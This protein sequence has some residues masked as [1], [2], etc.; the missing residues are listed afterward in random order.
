M[1]TKFTGLT[2]AVTEFTGFTSAVT[3]FTGL[4]TEF[5]VSDAVF[6]DVQGALVTAS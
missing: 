4:V 5:T 6:V 2:G 3:E 1:V